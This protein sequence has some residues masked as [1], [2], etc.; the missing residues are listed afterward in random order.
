MG[1]KCREKIGVTSQCSRPLTRRLIEALWLTM[2]LVY[3]YLIYLFVFLVGG[4]SI[5]DNDYYCG[6]PEDKGRWSVL[7]IDSD[8]QTKYLSQISDDSNY[9]DTDRKHYWYK[10]GKNIRLCSP[11]YELRKRV[12]D[13]SRE[14]CFIYEF[15]FE[16]DAL[17]EEVELVCTG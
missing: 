6:D 9:F 3:S 14:G 8:L 15:L 1:N 16:D 10:S 2:K 11:S 5:T 13:V 17:I 4:C 12:F 7:H